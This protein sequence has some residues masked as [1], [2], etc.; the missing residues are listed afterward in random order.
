MASIILRWQDVWSE[1]NECNLKKVLRVKELCCLV[2]S[3]SCTSQA[4]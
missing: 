1:C 3:A 2:F 4:S